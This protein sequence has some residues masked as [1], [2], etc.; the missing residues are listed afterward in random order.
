MHPSIKK[1]LF[2]IGFPLSPLY[3]QLMVLRA[4]LYNKGIFKTHELSVPVVSV[5]NLTMGGTGKTPLVMYLAKQLVDRGYKPAIVSR[6]Y[7]GTSNADVNIVTDGTRILMDAEASGDEPWLLANELS[8]VVVATGKNRVLPCN[9]VIRLYHCDII[10]L[11]DGFQH[12]KVARTIDLALFDV[13]VFAGNSRVFPGGELREPVK[14]LSRCSA[15][16]L[17]G[18]NQSNKIR[19]DKCSDILLKKFQDKELFRFTGSYHRAFQYGNLNE[20][21]ERKTIPVSELPDNL[22]CFCGIANPQRFN[23]LLL[24]NRI[25]TS[26]FKTFDD[27]HL[28]SDK[29]L[30]QLFTGAHNQNAPGF[31]TTEKDISKITNILRHKLPVFTLPIEFNENHD[32]NQF[33]TKRLVK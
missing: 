20:D 25:L 12:L 8:G 24:E 10:I 31:L 15:I 4:F 16:V 9:E 6:G 26:G 3:S 21:L 14:A 22:F 2:A 11:D 33:I 32:F 17:T 23:Q 30:D 7:R 13:D 29:D 19:S 5:G 18:V 27:H 28:Y 1:V